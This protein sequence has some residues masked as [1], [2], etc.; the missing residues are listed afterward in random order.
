[1]STCRDV[2]WQCCLIAML[3][4]TVRVATVCQQQIQRGLCRQQQS[5]VDSAR[6]TNTLCMSQITPAS[7]PAFV[8]KASGNT[9]NL[10]WRRLSFDQLRAQSQYAGLPALEQLRFESTADYRWIPILDCS[11]STEQPSTYE[12][13]SW[14][15]NVDYRSCKAFAVR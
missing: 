7:G 8:G 14:L 1:M 4:G 5:V 15:A 12:Y 10:F 11:R 3:T 9:P 13:K 2:R 6:V